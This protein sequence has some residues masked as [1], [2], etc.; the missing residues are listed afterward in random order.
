MKPVDFKEGNKP[1]R[2]RPWTFGEAPLMLKVLDKQNKQE[3]VLSLCPDGYYRVG[4]FSSGRDNFQKI[5]RKYEQLD[6]SPCGVLE[7]V[8]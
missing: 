4:A 7:V 6:G 5:M 2:V 3:A 8:E 1:A